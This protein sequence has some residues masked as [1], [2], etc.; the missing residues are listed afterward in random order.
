MPSI[1]RPR[2]ASLP[3]GPAVLALVLMASLIGCGRLRGQSPDRS[4]SA[5]E[6]SVADT[7]SRDPID[8]A[9]DAVD[10]ARRRLVAAD[11]AVAQAR[12]QLDSALAN[13]ERVT[14]HAVDDEILS[15]HSA[16]RVNDQDWA[17]MGRHFANDQDWGAMGH[18]FSILGQRIA[19]HAQ[20]LAHNEVA[21]AQR[22]AQ[23]EAARAMREAQREMM[24]ED[25][26]HDDDWDSSSHCHCRADNDDR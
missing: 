2:H 19:L 24:R 20:H 22:E 10:A 21:R 11:A 1:V 8:R 25:R 23:S 14:G 3:Y 4:A 9:L 13:V 12:G 7:G 26:D 18:H 16:G 17:E 6:S 15:D 5:G